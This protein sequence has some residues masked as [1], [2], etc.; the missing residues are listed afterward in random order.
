MIG[1]A[2]TGRLAAL[3]FSLT[4]A[5]C[6]ADECTAGRHGCDANVAENCVSIS[7]GEF[8][9]HTTWS[10]VDC[11]DDLCLP[12]PEGLAEAFCALDESPD[13]EC[14]EELRA[15]RDASRCMDGAVVTWRYGYRADEFYCVE[16]KACVDISVEGF[17]PSCHAQAFCSGLSEPEPLCQPGIGT[18]CRDASTIFYCECGFSRNAH[19]CEDPGPSCTYVNLGRGLPDQGVCR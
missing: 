2:F 8:D 17:D 1:R 5:G 4:V 11:G 10:R 13:P 12:S 14:P 16:G 3:L 7:E 6:A 19:A 15:L 9:S 18:A